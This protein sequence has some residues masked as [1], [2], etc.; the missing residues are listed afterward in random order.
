L[1]GGWETFTFGPYWS[2]WSTNFSF[3]LTA[4]AVVKVTDAFASGDRFNI[5]L[6]GSETINFQ[7]SV[8]TVIGANVGANYDAAFADPRWS[9]WSFSLPAGTYDIA[10]DTASSPFDGGGGAIELVGRRVLSFSALD[11]AAVAGPA[12]EPVSWTLMIAGFGMCGAMLRRRR[13]VSF[14]A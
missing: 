9:S 4:P 8:P 2:P 7:S 3:T 11:A 13:A 10:G 1:N 5:H 6:E 14:P 12:P